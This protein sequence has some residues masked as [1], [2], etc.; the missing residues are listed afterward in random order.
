ML[1]FQNKTLYTF[2]NLCFL[3]KFDLSTCGK[4]I[5]I[6]E[7]YK[8]QKEYWPKRIKFSKKS[9]QAEVNEPNRSNEV[10]TGVPLCKRIIVSSLK[11]I[12]YWN[13]GWNESGWKESSYLSDI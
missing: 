12:Y 6:V 13:N 9:D 2:H 7:P 8:W 4:S 5:C 11:R 1:C 3:I 10:S